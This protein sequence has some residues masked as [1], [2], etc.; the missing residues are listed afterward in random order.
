MRKIQAVI[1]GVLAAGIVAAGTAFGSSLVF[2]PN[3]DESMEARMNALES[4]ARTASLDINHWKVHGNHGPAHTGGNG[5]GGVPNGN[6]NPNPN[7]SGNGPGGSPGGSGSNSEGSGQGPVSH[8]TGNLSTP[9]P[10]PTPT[11]QPK[12]SCMH[13]NGKTYSHNQEWKDEWWGPN[14]T[15]VD[16][17]GVPHVTWHRYSRGMYRCDNGNVRYGGVEHEWRRA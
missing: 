8:I 6:T 7:P 10:T 15:R 1:L 4:W 16:R 13:D 5:S 12:K 17:S 3:A 11:P 2:N 9:T 14:K